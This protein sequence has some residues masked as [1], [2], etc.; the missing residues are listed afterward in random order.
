MSEVPGR[1]ESAETF[2]AML[3]LKLIWSVCASG[4][5]VLAAVQMGERA[6]SGAWIL[7]GVF[8]AFTIVWASYRKVLASR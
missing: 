2:R 4:G 7:A 3:N 6:P 5:I 8:A 1:N